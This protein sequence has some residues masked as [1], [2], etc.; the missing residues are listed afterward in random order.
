M[1]FL[2]FSMFFTFLTYYEIAIFIQIIL[3][4]W[5]H[6]DG[7]LDVCLSVLT[8]SIFLRLLPF[9]KDMTLDVCLDIS[10]ILN[11]SVIPDIPTIL[12]ISIIQ[13][14]IFLNSHNS[15]I[16]EASRHGQCLDKSDLNFD[17]ILDRAKPLQSSQIFW[18]MQ[19]PENLVYIYAKL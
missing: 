19:R 14:S 13:R 5:F 12:K 10:D 3:S 2:T 4:L 9:Q 11:I 6:K 7:T 1:F 16:F 8:F 17:L 18:A 15:V